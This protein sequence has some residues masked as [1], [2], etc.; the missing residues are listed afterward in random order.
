MNSTTGYNFDKERSNQLPTPVNTR[1]CVYEDKTYIGESTFDQ[2]YILI[3]KSRNADLV[4][5]HHAI[6]DI[7]ALVQLKRGQAFLFNKNLGNGLRLNGQSVKE[8]VLNAED[9]IQ[10]GPF[11]LVFRTGMSAEKPASVNGTFDGRITFYPKKS[12]PAG[13]PAGKSASKD[14]NTFCVKLLNQYASDYQRQRA[15]NNLARLLKRKVS[16][17]EQLLVR[18]EFVLKK[19]LD[20]STADKWI[21]TLQQGGILCQLHSQDAA[22]QNEKDLS[23]IGS[24]SPSMRGV[25]ATTAVQTDVIIEKAGTAFGND[26]P[27]DWLPIEDDEDEDEIWEAPFSVKEKLAVTPAKAHQ[28][29]KSEPRIQII[30]AMG[31]SVVDMCFLEK[32]KR[33]FLHTTDGRICLAENRGERKAFA[34]FT[35]ERQGYVTSEGKKRTLLDAFQKEE[36]LY[37]KRKQLY[38]TDRKPDQ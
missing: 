5:D 2:D 10:I 38:P 31:D 28:I 13:A 11:S 32:G 36:Y 12:N 4:L 20:R 3:G 24:S 22:K 33:Y 30:K 8:S 27:V 34:Y 37:R 25:H 16:S 1:F 26:I 17:V 19:H 35:P 21:S 23:F 15:A 9:V 14:K 29:L 18:P 6:A 7:H